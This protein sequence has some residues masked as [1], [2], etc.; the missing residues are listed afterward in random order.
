[1]LA[2]HGG[3]DLW[4]SEVLDLELNSEGVMDGENNEKVENI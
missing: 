3:K 2:V 1:V 4:K